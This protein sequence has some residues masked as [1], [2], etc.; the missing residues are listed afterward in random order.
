MQSRPPNDIERELASYVSNVVS[1]F[2]SEIEQNAKFQARL[3][4]TDTTF[5][6]CQPRHIRVAILVRLEELGYNPTWINKIGG[7]TEIFL[8]G[9]LA[10]LTYRISWRALRL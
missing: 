7:L 2:V 3:G 6:I 4:R 8:H 9:E 1:V 10:T 5:E